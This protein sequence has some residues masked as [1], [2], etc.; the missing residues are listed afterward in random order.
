ML[1]YRHI[2]R[3]TTFLEQIFEKYQKISNICIDKQ[4]NYVIILNVKNKCSNLKEENVMPFA[5]FVIFILTVCPLIL[6]GLFHEEML[7]KI[8]DK[9]IEDIRSQIAQERRKKKIKVIKNEKKSG[10]KSS[11]IPTECVA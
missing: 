5:V 2:E 9:I 1:L 3:V 11:D 8:E 4:K 7:I 10:S 6:W